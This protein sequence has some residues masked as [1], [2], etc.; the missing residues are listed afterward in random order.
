VTVIVV[1]FL[2]TYILPTFQ[3]LLSSIQ[4]P[5]PWPTL[6]VMETS[7]LLQRFWPVIILFF[8]LLIYIFYRWH[9]TPEGRY[10][11]SRMCL[12]L[13]VFGSLHHKAVLSRFSR[14]LGT[15]LSSGVSILPALEVTRRT[16]GNAVFSEAIARVEE[17]IRDGHSLAGPLG[18]SGIFPPMM[19]EMINV[20]EETGALDKLLEKIS[21]F[22]D[23]EV[24][25]TVDRLTSLVEPM[26]IIILGC[27]IGLVIISV[28]LPVFTMVGGV[29]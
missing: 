19:V 12:K 6:V 18:E 27:L 5:L 13:P 25:D 17:S 28:L 24:R 14:T 16:A 2:L 10:K 7:S 3:T 15:L 29:Q 26:L 4:V 9:K 1:I 8:T 23:R 21:D 20:G 22:Y 11:V